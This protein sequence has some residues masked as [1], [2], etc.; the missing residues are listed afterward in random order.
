MKHYLKVI[1]ISLIAGS[2]L[3]SSCTGKND[4]SAGESIEV[5]EPLMDSENNTLSIEQVTDVINGKRIP[6]KA[7][8]TPSKENEASINSR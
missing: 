1:F 5:S 2:L 7:P 6:Y 8:K 4:I 3:L